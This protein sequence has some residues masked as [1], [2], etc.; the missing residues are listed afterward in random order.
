MPRRSDHIRNLTPAMIEVLILASQGHSAP[1]TA[2]TRGV[3]LDTIK[4][5]RSTLMR[6]LGAD[7]MT[8][9]VAV[10][11]RRGIIS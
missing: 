9:A 2:E 4:H 10:A 5:Q 6:R 1:S 7:N 8:H 11:M 3:T